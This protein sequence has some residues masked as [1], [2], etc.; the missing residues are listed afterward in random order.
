MYIFIEKNISILPRSLQTEIVV[1][2]TYIYSLSLN[3]STNSKGT[4]LSKDFFL[5]K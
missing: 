1:L 4:I 3:L 5:T 2:F